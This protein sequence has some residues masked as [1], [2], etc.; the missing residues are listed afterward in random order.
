[1]TR[2]ILITGA[3]GFVGRHLLALLARPDNEIFGTSFPHRP[4][5]LEEPCRSAVC[6]LDI[7]DGSRLRELVADRRPDWI[8]HLAA[9]SSV[10]LS[11]SRRR[12]TMETNLMGTLSLLEAVRETVPQARVLFVSSADVYGVEGA[13]PAPLRED[14]RVHAAS[15]YAVSKISG[16]LLARFYA[17]VEEMDVILARSFPHTGPGQSPDFVCS[18]WARQIAR[19]EKG[20]EEP[21]IRIGNIRVTRDFSD[22]RDVVRAYAL[23]LERGE[24]GE[25]YNVA[26]GR[27]T[28]LDEVMKILL[29]RTDRAIDV[30]VDQEKFRKIDIPILTG[31]PGKLRAATGW[32]PEIPLPRT[33][34]DL[35]DDWRLRV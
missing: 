7:R 34:N 14:H 24:R 19:I 5:E 16:E 26:S 21:V 1:M 8:F 25:T 10:G 29:S 27:P 30:K 31:D 18:D 9:V 11:W 2:R 4:E 3:S 13:E 20:L 15:P 33:L 17:E 22:V 35:L 28:P 23:L 32:E 6:H 12:E